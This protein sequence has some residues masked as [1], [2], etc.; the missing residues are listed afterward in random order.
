MMALGEI[1]SNI[2]VDHVRGDYGEGNGNQLQYSCLDNPMGEELVELQY[3]WSQCIGHN[4]ETKQA[5]R[6][7][8]QL[9][10]HVRLFVTP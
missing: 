5:R 7:S 6:D 1:V 3:M 8:V 10:S 2:I 4:S 9:L